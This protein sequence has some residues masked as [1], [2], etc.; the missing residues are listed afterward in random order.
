MNK[1]TCSEKCAGDS[2]S[3]CD[4]VIGPVR[5]IDAWYSAIA[6]QPTD[7]LYLEPDE[8]ARIW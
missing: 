8:R 2:A 4:R 1:R 6:V 5:N 3:G 7:R